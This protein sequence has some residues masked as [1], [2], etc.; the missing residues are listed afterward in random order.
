MTQEELLSVAEVIERLVKRFEEQGAEY[1]RKMAEHRDSFV[2]RTEADAKIIE[3]LRAEI[4]RVNEAHGRTKVENDGLLDELA[5]QRD[6]FTAE[7]AALKSQTPKQHPVKV[8]EWVKR[9][10]PSPMTPAGGVAKVTDVFE[11]HGL[12]VKIER[13]DGIKGTWWAK[14]C[15]PCDPPAA[16]HD[17]EAG[18]AAAESAVRTEPV[19]EETW[20]ADVGSVGTVV[21]T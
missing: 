6:A 21:T 9:L 8:G 17:T 16:D 1:E 2:A 5:A 20:L 12:A 4:I 10:T 3:G 19:P 11:V 14:C 15:E 18:K 7:V 13:P